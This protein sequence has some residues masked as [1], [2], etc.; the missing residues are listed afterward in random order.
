MTAPFAQVA[1][2]CVLKVVANLAEI[3]LEFAQIFFVYASHIELQNDTKSNKMEME[4]KRKY[5]RPIMEELGLE[6]D[7]FLLAVSGIQA[8]RSYEMETEA[9]EDETKKQGFNWD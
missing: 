2:L 7:S 8:A 5:V 3:R 4:T 9:E 1:P 6:S